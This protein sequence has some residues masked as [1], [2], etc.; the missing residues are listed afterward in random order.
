M[1][2]KRWCCTSSV[3]YGFNTLPICIC[4]KSSRSE[5]DA[6]KENGARL[7]SCAANDRLTVRDERKVYKLEYL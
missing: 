6:G 3:I 5:R 7:K 1:E 4:L 2:T